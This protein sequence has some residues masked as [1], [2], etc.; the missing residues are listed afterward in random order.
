M[1]INIL[2]LFNKILENNGV[3][4][5]G[6]QVHVLNYTTGNKYIIED[7]YNNFYKYHDGYNK[8]YIEFSNGVEI[9]CDTLKTLLF[10]STT[11]E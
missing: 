4:T 1:Q 7:M 10:Y 3:D 5:I 11:I 2:N 6:G 9:E 8:Y